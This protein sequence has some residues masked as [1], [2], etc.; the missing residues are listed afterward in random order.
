MPRGGGSTKP[1]SID[2]SVEP[3]AP[4]VIVARD[5]LRVASAAPFESRCVLVP[6]VGGTGVSWRLVIA[7][8][9]VGTATTYT[10]PG[11]RF[12]SNDVMR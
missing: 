10:V 9:L 3:N 5:S 8:S 11:T 2:V 12:V 1:K 4:I 7:A 6:S